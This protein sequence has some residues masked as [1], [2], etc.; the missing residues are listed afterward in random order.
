[1]IMYLSTVWKGNKGY[2]YPQKI[3][4]GRVVKNV[5]NFFKPRELQNYME[6]KT[7]CLLFLHIKLRRISQKD[8]PH[9]S[10]LAVSKTDT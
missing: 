9:I 5:S 2:R 8:V 4:Q 6:N 10:M 1:M 7:L 3:F